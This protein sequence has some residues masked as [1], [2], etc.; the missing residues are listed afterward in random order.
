MT[1]CIFVQNHKK[2]DEIQQQAIVS[3]I[4]PKQIRYNSIT[5]Q[6]YAQQIFPWKSKTKEPNKIS[7]ENSQHAIQAQ[8]SAFDI[9][10]EIVYINSQNISA[11]V[12][13]V[14]GSAKKSDGTTVTL[15]NKKFFNA[16]SITYETDMPA[17]YAKLY[18]QTELTVYRYEKCMLMLKCQPQIPGVCWPVDALYDEEKK[19]IGM[20][21]P[22]V[23]GRPLHLAIFNTTELLK[24]FPIWQRVDVVTL[25]ITMLEKILALHQK[26]IL[27]G[28]IN[29]ASI[30]VVDQH[31]V[32]FTD[33]D[34]YQIE[35]F[36]CLRRNI[37]FMPPELQGRQDVFLAEKQ[38]E[39]FAITVLAFM[40]L[41]P[42]KFPYERSM[43]ENISD[44]IIK[45]K[46][47]Y[48][49][50]E[51]HS[52]ATPPG[53]WRFVWSHLTP[54]VK[55]LFF[56]TFKHGGKYSL[57]GNR[58]D[59]ATVLNML[60][61][62]KTELASEETRQYDPKSLEL[63]PTTFRRSKVNTLVN[64]ACCG[65]EY[66]KVIRQSTLLKDTEA[67]SEPICHNC[68][69]TRT[70]ESFKCEGCEKQFYYSKGEVYIRHKKQ[71]APQRLCFACKRKKEI[72]KSCGK[73][74]YSHKLLRGVCEYCRETVPC[75][76]CGKR[77]KPE[78]L[79]QGRCKA[80]NTTRRSR[81]N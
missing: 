64:C 39:C 44:N 75:S 60:R 62:Y 49:Y 63:F 79:R 37:L 19:F 27:F 48:A 51:Q 29:P 24:N 20:L 46:F 34:Q 31:T 78:H 33:T 55:E 76:E 1:F 70:N 30:L 59:V 54:Y 56:N 32:Y 15:R 21:I 2:L 72:C 42:G 68:W 52:E 57:S 41:L 13:T 6:G 10:K 71:Y 65:Q 43:T 22:K 45:M 3:G 17:Y 47:P 66:R 67:Q 35:G 40:T 4:N 74:V 80:C 18:N 36:P 7:A 26:N 11:T 28:C 5:Q 58:K 16:D 14:S 23:E 73:E 50:G 25:A 9:V 81:W 38:N 8:S 61:K 12:P 69:S 77:L 53:F